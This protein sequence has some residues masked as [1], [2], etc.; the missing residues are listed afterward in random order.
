MTRNY[1]KI[2]LQFVFKFFRLITC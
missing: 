2:E 1:A